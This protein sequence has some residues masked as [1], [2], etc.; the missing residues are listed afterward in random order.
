MLDRQIER[1]RR[2]GRIEGLVVATS[3]E[4]TDTPV[5]ALCEQL[6]VECFRGSLADVLER[7]YQAALPH[8]PRHVMRLTGDCPLTDPGLL[9][10]LAEQHL[11][12]A[13]NY[14]SN[15]HER[16]YPDGLDA[17][18][19]SFAALE[20]ARRL[21]KTQFERE[22]VTPFMYQGGHG[23]RLGALK[24]TVDRSKLRWTVDYPE[25]YEFV[26]QVFAALYPQNPAFGMSDVLRLLEQRPELAAINARHA[27]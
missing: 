14:S 7:F 18:L 19:F 27:Q 24:D 12:E 20:A 2:A 5:A 8:A 10:A 23:F 13:N 17:E 22:H 9:D 25:D 26:C 11:A 4:P 15:V 1:I 21:A 6:G 16:T 3:I